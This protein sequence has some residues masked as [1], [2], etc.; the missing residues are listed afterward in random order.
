MEWESTDSRSFRRR[1]WLR[2]NV[3]CGRRVCPIEILIGGVVNCAD[4]SVAVVIIVLADDVAADLEVT[5]LESRIIAQQGSVRAAVSH[6][7]QIA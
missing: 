3:R 1:S 7:L 2:S 5:R 6:G 4:A